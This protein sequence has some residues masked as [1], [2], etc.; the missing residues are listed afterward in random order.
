MTY[1][2][3]ACLVLSLLAQPAAA[4][5]PAGQQGDTLRTPVIRAAEKPSAQ[6]K[7]A[8]TVSDDTVRQTPAGTQTQPHAPLPWRDKILLITALVGALVGLVGLLFG[9]FQFALRRKLEQDKAKE[10]TRGQHEARQEIKKQQSLTAQEKYIEWQRLS[11][12]TIKLLGSPDIEPMPVELLDTF[13]R[14]DMRL[15]QQNFV[16]ERGIKPDD[17]LKYTF[18]QKKRFLVIVGDPGSGKT[19]LMQYYAMRCLSDQGYRAF[20]FDEPVLPLYLPLRE[21]DHNDDLPANLQKWAE[22]NDKGRDVSAD[23]FHQWL[24]DQP[25]LILLD[26]LD[27]IVTK[28]KRRACCMRIGRYLTAYRKAR[29]VLTT[30]R[31]GLSGADNS[32]EEKIQLDFEHEKADLLDFTLGQQKEFLTGWYRAVYQAEKCP[33]GCEPEEWQE[34]V[35]R[36]AE[37]K[38]TTII[39]Y[40]GK[41][42][43]KSLRELAGI[44]L[45]LQIMAIIWLERNFLP[46]TLGE[47]FDAALNYLL[48]QRDEHRAIPLPL[49]TTDARSILERVALHMQDTLTEDQIPREKLLTS[50]QEHL[51][52][53]DEKLSPPDAR[54]FCEYLVKRA[55]LLSVH[56]QEHYIF[57]PKIFGEFLAGARL[58][59]I[60]TMDNWTQRLVQQ[61]G[62]AWWRETLRFFMAKAGDT[63]FDAFMRQFFASDKSHDL[64][65][66]QRATLRDLIQ[67][68]PSA[69]RKVE[70]LRDH[71]LSQATTPD[72]KNTILECLRLIG[73]EDARRAI[74][75][76]RGRAEG[77]AKAK[78]DDVLLTG[79]AEQTTAP[80]LVTKLQ[81]LGAA[82]RTK[83][84]SFRNSIEF[85]AEYL[86]IPGGSYVYQ[87]GEEN[88]KEVTVPDLYFARYPVTNKQYRR[89]IA[90]LAGEEET[91]ELLQL[92]TFSSFVAQTQQFARL[93]EM[94]NMAGYLEK[95]PSEWVRQ[96]RSEE[97]DDR[98]FNQDEQ[99]VV[100][101]SWYAARLYCFWLALLQQRAA[102]EEVRDMKKLVH[103][104]RLPHEWE[105]EWAAGGGTRTYPWG[106]TPEPDDTL[107]N[108]GRDVGHTTPVGAYPEGATPEGLM[109]MAGNVWEWQEN[110]Y[111]EVK[112]RRAHR[113]GSWINIPNLLRCAVRSIYFVLPDNRV[114]IL[115]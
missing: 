48:G 33:P 82:L 38:T 37:A 31:Y 64:S 18:E 115:G 21:F 98:R 95:D 68:V 30:R 11:L 73:S 58:A 34:E 94:K 22:K 105:W 39:D 93:P 109:D 53:I 97:D 50:L 6:Q 99:P 26:G 113:G 104:Y 75:E 41:P 60:Y 5:T 86:L 74:E 108:F 44:P 88:E 49:R 15:G 62:E 81:E 56:G 12:G 90:Y 61:F 79:F 40:L 103:L 84:A 47:L 110:W 51:D 35:Q 36:R 16:N 80:E 65:Q 3:A 89:F 67:V 9:F 66:E 23:D 14:L 70:A 43:N 46:N 85:N 87:K 19:T 2:L 57:R 1:R 10:A 77:E 111:H 76:F 107:A 69:D 112:I 4:Q 28:D 101:V 7:K 78:A 17:A 71:L 20:G 91:G 29:F 42:E 92:L 102:G 8:T 63:G 24:H 45:I 96:L 55:G 83:P 25:T 100:G 54:A 72:Q 114:N 59:A 52:G 32:K 27:E 13:V 106:N